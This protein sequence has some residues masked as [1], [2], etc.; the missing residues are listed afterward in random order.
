MERAPEAHIPRHFVSS[1]LERKSNLYR[2]SEAELVCLGREHSIAYAVRFL[3]CNQALEADSNLST[4]GEVPVG[5]NEEAEQRI[6]RA[7]SKIEI[8]NVSQV[9]RGVRRG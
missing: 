9:E 7:N 8:F 6:T 1:F 5:S 2:N 3:S 4:A